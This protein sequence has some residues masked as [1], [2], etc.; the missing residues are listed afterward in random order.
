MVRSLGGSACAPSI[1]ARFICLSPASHTSA[2]RIVT[3][4]C[5]PACASEICCP[6]SAASCCSFTSLRCCCLPIITFLLVPDEALAGHERKTLFPSR[7]LFCVEP[8]LGFM[9]HSLRRLSCR[10]VSYGTE[11]RKNN[12][13]RRNALFTYFSLCCHALVN[14]AGYSSYE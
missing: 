5:L 3:S 7:Y 9:A 12:G 6:S 13:P 11:R 1:T 10:V 14:H 8:L 4:A 2:S